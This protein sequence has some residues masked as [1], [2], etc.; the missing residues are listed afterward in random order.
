[1]I[2]NDVASL[3]MCEV[4]DQGQTK[5]I[6]RIIISTLLCHCISCLVTM[7]L[8]FRLLYEWL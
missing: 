3:Q 4:Q 6:P 5:N 1:L 2:Q 8:G 7:D